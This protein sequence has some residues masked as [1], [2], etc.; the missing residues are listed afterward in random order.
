MDYNYAGVIIPA[1][2]EEKCIGTTI[3]A[4]KGISLIREILVVDD[5]STDNTAEVAVR[6]GAILLRLKQNQGKG[7]AILQGLKTISCP[8]VLLLD[9]DL[10]ESAIEAAK[11]I[12]PIQEGK[13][14]VAIAR[15]A[16]IPGKHG[17]GLVKGLSRMGV[18]LLTGRDFKTVLS[19]Q[20]A[21]RKDI[22]NH[23]FFKYRRFGIEFGMTVDLI[24]QGFKI[25]EVD[26]QMSHR[27]TEMDWPGILHRA[28]QFWD[29]STVL[30]GKTW[31][32]VGLK[33]LI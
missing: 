19:G 5:G 1:Y 18:R 20:R 11:L 31:E 29:I 13:A 28:R 16:S 32:K 10:C 33:K 22:I 6:E 27:V 26:V 17:F 2:N 3:K 14:D 25:C 9:A 21:F 7:Y 12:R 23:D 24:N 15:F 30:I 8:I 4:L